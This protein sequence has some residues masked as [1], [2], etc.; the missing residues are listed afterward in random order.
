MSKIISLNE[1]VNEINKNFK[2][3]EGL[4]KII[5]IVERYDGFDW[6]KYVKID[7]KTN[8]I[9]NLFYENENFEMF[10]VTWMPNQN[11]TIH[12]HSKNGCVMKVLDGHLMEKQFDPNT[13]EFI[14]YKIMIP[15]DI[16]FINNETCYP[17]IINIDDNI[18]TSLHIYSPPRYKIK[19][20]N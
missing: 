7:N 3:D 18:T 2:G 19:S 20:Y 16:G 6:N 17:Q 12:D 9:K 1:L 14:G 8:Y 10:I 15:D 13:I 4:D 5:N 11:S